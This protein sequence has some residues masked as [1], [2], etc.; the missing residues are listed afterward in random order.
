MTTQ[1]SDE[2]ARKQAARLLKSRQAL[3]EAMKRDVQQLRKIIRGKT[4]KQ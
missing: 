3:T 2:K 4:G 1:S